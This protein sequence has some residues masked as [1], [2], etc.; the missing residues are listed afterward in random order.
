MLWLPIEDQGILFPVLFGIAFAFLLLFQWAPSTSL[1]HYAWLGARL[2]FTAPLIAL[3]LMLLKSGLHQHGFPD[4]PVNSFLTL[5]KS[6]PIVTMV[7]ALC[8]LFA[9]YSMKSGL[10]R[11]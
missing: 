8:G 1:G 10:G 7:G 6:V 4:F 11:I 2:A 9:S 3:L 5:F